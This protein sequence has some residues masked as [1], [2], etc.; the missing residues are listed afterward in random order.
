MGRGSHPDRRAGPGD[1]MKVEMSV[2]TLINI[3]EGAGAVAS[4]PASDE[5]CDWFT[6]PS[7][8]A[9]ALL[10]IL[11]A[12]PNATPGRP[13]GW[14]HSIE[15]HA[16]IGL[17]Y[18]RPVMLIAREIAAM[19]GQSVPTARRRLQEMKGGSRLKKLRAIKQA[20][21]AFHAARRVSR[22]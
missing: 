22:K 4:R 5:P 7:T 21:E 2:A 16:V 19:T 8:A 13:K 11:H 15:L 17:L 1:G 3:L 14:T 9:D 20:G 10:D 12:L 18:D 6:I